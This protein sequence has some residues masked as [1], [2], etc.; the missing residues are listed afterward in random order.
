MT[1]TLFW[2][3]YETWGATPAQDKPSQFAGIR[4][5]EALNIIGDPL[6]IYCQPVKDCLPHPEAC[7]ITGVTPQ[8]ALE[9]GISEIEFFR[10][11][12]EQLSQSGTCGVGYNSIRF[13][14]E[15]TRYGLY[16]NFYDPYEREWKNGN[17]RWDIIDMVRLCYALRPE[18]LSWP[19][20]EDGTPSF[21]LENLTKENGLSHEAAHDALSDVTATIALARLIRERQPQL[22][23]YAYSLR[24]KQR[25]NALLDVQQR[26]PILH[27]SSRFPAKQ[28]CAALMAPLAYHPRNNNS[29][30]CYDLSVD[31]QPLLSLSV[32]EI[33]ER[34]FVKQEDLPEGVDR[35]P[36][37]EIHI[38][39][40][41]M[42]LTT[43]MLEENNAQ[44]LGINKQ[45]CEL[46]WQQLRHADLSEKIQAVYKDSNFAESKD[47]EQQLYMGF[48]HDHDKNLCRQIRQASPEHLSDYIPQLKD[49]RLKTLLFRYRAR[50]FP[51]TLTAD[52]QKR[53][54]E[55]C[56]ERLTNPEFAASITLEDFFERLAILAEDTSLDQ[57]IVQ[58]LFDY[59]DTVLE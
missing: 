57:T 14:D 50:H 9:K 29:V 53:W 23:E 6:V 26:K 40:S 11:I 28:G 49:K 22:Y 55:W 41:P 37:K 54:Q 33:I 39:K 45:A 51:H 58:A 30:I 36:L 27:I 21:K 19:L 17:S 59:G 34:L 16:R 4:T 5:D 38:N 2:H 32:E 10:A 24:A 13:D 20:N 48:I 52:E 35:I 56:Y 15:V 18:T 1:N 8:I 47:P 46:H 44:R 3:D 43:K 31:P 7:L 12:H 25:V 42:V